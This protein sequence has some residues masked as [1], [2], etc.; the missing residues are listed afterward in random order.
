[1]TGRGESEVV[2]NY[3]CL[4]NVKV[5]QSENKARKRR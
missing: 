5:Y 2:V 4:K 3:S 1:M